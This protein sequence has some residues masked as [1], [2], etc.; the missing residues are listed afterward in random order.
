MEQLETQ[1][2]AFMKVLR[3]RFALMVMELQ[4]PI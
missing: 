4:L 1:V 3:M 2:Q